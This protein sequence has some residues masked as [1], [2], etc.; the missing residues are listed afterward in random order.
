M[1]VMMRSVNPDAVDEID[2]NRDRR[3]PYVGQSV[4]FHARPGE[5]RMG[6][7]AAPAIVTAVEDDD[8]VELL[9]IYAAEDSVLRLK[10]PRKT[11]QNPFNAWSFN[12]YDQ[13]HY[14]PGP[15][16][17]APPEPSA[18]REMKELRDHVQELRNR[19]RELEEVTTAPKHQKSNR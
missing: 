9:A 3:R 5:A 6:K 13:D 8:H 18:V 10:I 12:D 19:V 7:L 14:R 2:P 17:A 11:E 1:A 16:L 4:I 15:A